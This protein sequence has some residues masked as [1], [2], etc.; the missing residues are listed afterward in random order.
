MR[1]IEIEPI[2]SV[3]IGFNHT[4]IMEATSSNIS[5]SDLFALVKQYDKDFYANKDGYVEKKISSEVLNADGTP[6]TFYH[7]SD[8]VFTE[9][10]PNA[11]IS[12]GVGMLGK[13]F[14]FTDKKN[15][16]KGYGKELYAVYLQMSNPY[17]ATEAEMGCLNSNKLKAQGYDGVILKSPSGN[18]YMVFE[19]TQIKSA[20]NGE[21]GNIGTFDS[22]EG[23]IQFQDRQV[24]R[25]I[26]I[27]TKEEYN[28]GIARF[29]RDEIGAVELYTATS[30][31]ARKVAPKDKNEFSRWLANKTLNHNG[32]EIKIIKIYCPENTYVFLA[33]GYMKGRLLKVISSKYIESIEELRRE[34]KNEIDGN[35]EIADLWFDTLSSGRRDAEWYISLDGDQRTTSGYDSFSSDTRERNGTRDNRTG[36]ADYTKDLKEATRLLEEFKQKFG[37]ADSDLELPHQ[38]KD[39][40]DTQFQDRQ[41]YPDEAREMLV[42]IFSN[43]ENI[44]GLDVSESDRTVLSKALFEGAVGSEGEFIILDEYRPNRT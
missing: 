29:T 2:T 6:K 25:D 13:G 41:V 18:T 40:I 27:E 22:N 15:A 44:E 8:A 14:Y 21:K 39:R 3:G 10:N 7:G 38:D 37:W 36:R 20:Y 23:D 43:M 19:N 9:F 24:Y 11:P 12:T 33:T 16:A 32:K 30:D 35:A 1:A 17:I 34:F 5:I 42:K 26:D 28:N 31:F 4:P